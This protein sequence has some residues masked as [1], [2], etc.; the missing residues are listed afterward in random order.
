[1]HAF[2]ASNGHFEDA[3]N[4]L[5]HR[6]S[7]I[8]LGRILFKPPEFLHIQKVLAEIQLHAH[9]LEKNIVLH[10]DV[11]LA[12]ADIIVDESML[13]QSNKHSLA[14]I[15]EIVEAIVGQGLLVGRN[16]V[17]DDAL[18]ENVG[19]GSGQIHTDRGM[20]SIYAVNRGAVLACDAA[21]KVLG[22]H[23][24][25][26]GGVFLTTDDALVLR[27]C[28]RERVI[29]GIAVVVGHCVVVCCVAQTFVQ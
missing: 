22:A 28:V 9:S 5:V 12:S 23:S 29:V 14:L 19:G 15:V 8:L 20:R 11:Q 16:L 18:E 21:D 4:H 10:P 27:L 2:L 1:M 24:A 6:R 25:L 13:V 7:V 17:D 26:A 3:L